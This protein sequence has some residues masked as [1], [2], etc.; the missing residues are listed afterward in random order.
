MKFDILLSKNSEGFKPKSKEK[1]F[2][3]S[4]KNVSIFL[5]EE[6]NSIR[7]SGNGIKAPELNL[8]IENRSNREICETN[9]TGKED[10]LFKS[11]SNKQKYISKQVA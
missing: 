8:L 6:G 3:G 4:H 2:V 7:Y 5:P 10:I 1:K 9:P 11:L